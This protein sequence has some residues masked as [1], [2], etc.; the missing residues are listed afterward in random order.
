MYAKN[1]KRNHEFGGAFLIIDEIFNAVM[2][3]KI[4]NCWLCV[5]LLLY[6]IFLNYLH[7]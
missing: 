4:W 3:N 1:E 2:G 5:N 6:T 7:E